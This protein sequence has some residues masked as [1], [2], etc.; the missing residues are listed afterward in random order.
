MHAYWDLIY[1]SGLQIDT[2]LGKSL[3]K[4]RYTPGFARAVVGEQNQ[5]PCFV[6]KA[7][8]TMGKLGKH[9]LYHSEWTVFVKFN[10]VQN[11]VA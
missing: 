1:A 2:F 9:F 7:S 4:I 3:A 11:A 8:P 10:L 5:R 6:R